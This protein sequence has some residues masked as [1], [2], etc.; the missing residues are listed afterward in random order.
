[1]QIDTLRSMTPGQVHAAVDGFS[2]RYVADWETWLAASPSVRPKRFGETLRKWQATRPRK[3]RRLRAEAQHEPPYLDDLIDSAAEPLRVLADL[4]VKTICVGTLRQ[5]QALN[6]LWTIF[7]GM[8]LTEH[9]TC[10]GIT[11]AV[12]LLTDGRIGP[13]FDSNVQKKLGRPE[14]ADA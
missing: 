13:A 12:L 4:S 1:M 3:P 11:K 10:V 8:T 5:G 2:A 7:S 6:E 14:T 9:A